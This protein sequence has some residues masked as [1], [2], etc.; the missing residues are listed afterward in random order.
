M[1]YR[2][3]S[4]FI[5]SA[6]SKSLS[7]AA[8]GLNISVSAVSRQILLFERSVGLQLF[9]RS[10][11]GIMLTSEA[12]QLYKNILDFEKDVEKTLKR[13]ST[14]MLKI[15]ALQSTFDSLVL[16][17]LDKLDTKNIEVIV[18]TPSSLKEKLLA[19]NV[20]I[21]LTN[22][23]IQ[24]DLVSSCKI[25]SE[26]PVFVST[27]P[28]T[29]KNWQEAQKIIFTPLEHLWPKTTLAA[30]NNI[31]INSL[32]AAKSLIKSLNGIS[33]LP[34]SGISYSDCFVKD[35]AK[36]RLDT[37]YFATLGYDRLPKYYQQIFNLLRKI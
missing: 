35:I 10:K 29:K 9:I 3:L 18:G 36:E 30:K 34:K 22:E 7:N 12:E 26:R 33:I 4:A 16:P 14:R 6:K 13:E 5:M 24:N 31:K 15:G 23:L 11:N 1:D 19:K 27:R 28:I 25:F 8:K 37:I 17:L 20:D 32:S 2:Y 21:I